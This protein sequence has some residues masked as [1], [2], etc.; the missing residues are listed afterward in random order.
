MSHR[1]KCWMYTH[2][3]AGF[4]CAQHHHS[5]KEPL[6][7][8]CIRPEVLQALWGRPAE[9]RRQIWQH[10]GNAFVPLRNCPSV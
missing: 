8:R 2:S 9:I 3:S 4:D 1:A 7:G 6:V 5:C 10:I